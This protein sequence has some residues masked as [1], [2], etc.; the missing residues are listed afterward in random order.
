MK[1]H[2]CERGRNTI[3]RDRNPNFQMD[4]SNS[5]ATVTNSTGRGIKS[6]RWRTCIGEM[7]TEKSSFDKE[8]RD[9]ATGV[10]FFTN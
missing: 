1:V 2:C 7:V 5:K 8:K 10:N 9:M 4:L 6:R 3:K